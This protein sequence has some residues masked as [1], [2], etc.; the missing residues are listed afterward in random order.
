MVSRGLDLMNQR[1]D[2]WL[3]IDAEVDRHANGVSNSTLLVISARVFQMP[4]QSAENG[5]PTA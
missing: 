1:L 3:P 2:H 5:R 4:V